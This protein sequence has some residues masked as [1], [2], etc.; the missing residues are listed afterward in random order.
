MDGN[1]DNIQIYHMDCNLLC[2]G[3]IFNS[4][5]Y[6]GPYNARENGSQKSAPMR[7]EQLGCIFGRCIQQSSVLE[8][9]TD[10]FHFTDSIQHKHNDDLYI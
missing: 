1:V 7:A 10:I 3:H 9:V 2:Y 5:V 6:F 8:P 4:M